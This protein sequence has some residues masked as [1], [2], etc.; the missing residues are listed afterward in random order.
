MAFSPILNWIF[1]VC[2]RLLHCTMFNGCPAECHPL[3]I[4]GPITG[5]KGGAPYLGR[6]SPP[7]RPSAHTCLGDQWGPTPTPGTVTGA[8]PLGGGHLEDTTN[9]RKRRGNGWV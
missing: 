2:F 7:H 5:V 4:I 6:W 8:L 3:P 9:K 1:E